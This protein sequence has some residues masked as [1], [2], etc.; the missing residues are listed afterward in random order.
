MLS[1]IHL[2]LGAATGKQSAD[3]KSS[4]V[5][6]KSEHRSDAAQLLWGGELFLDFSG[7]VFFRSDFSAKIQK[8]DPPKISPL[9]RVLFS[10]KD[11][12][13]RLGGL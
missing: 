7:E 3:K 4:T 6:H 5:S 1:E 12:K 13:R 9:G 2:L 8:E 11:P 10:E